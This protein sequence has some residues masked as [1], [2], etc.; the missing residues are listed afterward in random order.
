MLAGLKLLLAAGL[1]ALLVATP[2]TAAESL[3]GQTGTLTWRTAE[4]R[5]EPSLSDPAT[6]HPVSRD[7]TIAAGRVVSDLGFY[8]SLSLDATANR[9]VLSF[10][11]GWC[12]LAERGEDFVGPVIT[13]TSLP[14]DQDLQV[15]VAESNL[16][17]TGTDLLVSGN[18]IA[19]DLRGHDISGGHIALIVAP[20]SNI[21]ERATLA[22]IGIG[23]ITLGLIRPRRRRRRG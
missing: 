16:G 14:A 13:L 3:I 21:A 17:V 23:L 20:G 2:A 8:P 9:L 15:S 19:I 7:F 11:D 10:S 12:C 6:S 5:E 18:R 4:V 22:L 1:T